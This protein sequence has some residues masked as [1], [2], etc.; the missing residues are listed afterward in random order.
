MAAVSLFSATPTP[1]NP[2]VS[3]SNQGGVT[4]AVTMVFSEPGYITHVRFFSSTTVEEYLYYGLVWQITE[5]DYSGGPFPSA[6][7]AIGDITVTPTPNTWVD[8][9]LDSPMQVEAGVPYR[10]GY[11]QA[12]TNLSDFDVRY[13]A[14]GGFFNAHSEVNGP[15]TAPEHNTNFP[16]IGGQVKQGTFRYH[17]S[18][19]VNPWLI[20]PVTEFGQGNYWVDVLF[21]PGVETPPMATTVALSAEA[22]KLASANADTDVEISLSAEGTKAAFVSAD[23]PVTVS[24]TAEAHKIAVVTTDPVELLV[25]LPTSAEVVSA[26]GTANTGVIVGLT[27]TARKLE[28]GPQIMRGFERIREIVYTYLQVA[29][30][31]YVDA[32]RKAWSVDEFWLPYPAKYD[33]YDPTLVTNADYPMIGMLAVGDAKHVR[34]DVLPDASQEYQSTFSTRIILAAR[35]PLGPDGSSWL[36]P[37]KEQ[38]MRL[39]SDLTRVMHGALLQGPGCG[40]P[41]EVFM[42]ETTLTTDYIEPQ[43]PN[44]QSKRWVVMSVTSVD[45]RLTEKTY[46]L[47]YGIA[48]TIAEEVGKLS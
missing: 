48:A 30:P 37:E 10:I 9:Q 39:C 31:Y 40:R 44:S 18:G 14:S 25:S 24:L 27:A 13:T 38:A 7:D 4:L 23:N 12:R 19:D 15:I 20:Y 26:S 34:V 3:D 28:T 8:I 17:G 42:E 11:Y 43:M 29:M 22:T 47:P 32:S 41:R 1:G 21:S 6:P 5:S 35:S 16:S 2:D 46:A 33:V 36:Q 45:F